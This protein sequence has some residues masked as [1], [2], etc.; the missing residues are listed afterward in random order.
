METLFVLD[1]VSGAVSCP[2]FTGISATGS[3][4]SLEDIPAG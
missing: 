1:I 4:R 2:A 3:F